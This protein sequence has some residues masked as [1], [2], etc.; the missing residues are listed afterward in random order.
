[1]KIGRRKGKNLFKL[2]EKTFKRINSEFYK[3]CPNKII[4]Q[5]QE[6]GEYGKVVTTDLDY[7]KEHKEED[8]YNFIIL[9]LLT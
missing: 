4:N 7:I 5:I 3:K 9:L 2:T 8:F 1:M 6:L